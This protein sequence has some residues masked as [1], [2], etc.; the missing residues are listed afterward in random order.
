[1][2]DPS[3]SESSGSEAD[4]LL[5]AFALD[6]VDPAERKLVERHLANDPVARGEVDKMRETAAALASLPADGEGTP[7]ALWSR[8]AGAIRSQE[9]APTESGPAGAA[10][11]TERGPSNVVP[12]AR[13][14]RSIPARIVMPVAAAAAIVIV[15][16]AVQVAT[17][18]PSRAGDLAAAYNHAVA[19]GAAPVSLQPQLGHGTVAAEIALQ[20]DGTGYL[21]NDHLAALPAGKTYQLWALVNRS[22]EQQAISAG[23]LGRAPRTAAFHVAGAPAAFAITV[24]NAPGAVSPTESPIAVGRIPT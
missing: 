20:S 15:V 22:N 2:S 21:R 19:G 4:D 24:E 18:T 6:A 8:I 10:A 9:L 13:R 17:R 3:R 14:P 7:P 1:M 5:G 11:D 23:V 16:L 12:I